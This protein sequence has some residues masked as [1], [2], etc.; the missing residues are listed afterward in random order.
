MQRFR[1][2]SLP[3]LLAALAAGCGDSA[4]GPVDGGGP[5]AAPSCTEDPTR[6]GCP[7]CAEDPSLAWCATCETD[8]SLHGCTL[9]EPVFP[10]LEGEVEILRDGTGIAH[11][12]AASDADAMY[13]SGYAQALDRL[14]QMDL[15]RRLALGRQA[16]V[17][18]EGRADRDETIRVMG[19]ADWA[20]ASAVRLRGEHAELY[21]LVTAWTAGVNA[22]IDEVLSGTAPLPYGFGADALDYEPEHWSVVDAMAVGRLLLFENANLI[23]YELLATIVR[24]YLPEIHDN[25]GLFEPLE[26]V[27]TL[28]PEDRPTALALD[29]RPPLPPRTA[30]HLPA[31]TDARMRAFAARLAPFRPS[32][33]NNWAIAGRHTENGRPLIASDPHQGLE[34]PS[35][36]WVHQVNSADAGGTINAVGFNFVGTPGIQLGHNARVAWTA[37][38]TYPDTMD[39]YEV[40]ATRTLV[41]VA[42]RGIPIDRHEEVIAVRDGAPRTILIDRVPGLGVLL[43]DDL[44]PLPVAGPGRRLLFRWTGFKP[45]NDFEVFWRFDTARDTDDFDAAAGEF[46]IG[47]FNWVAADAAGI[48]YRSGMLVPDRGDPAVHPPAF[49]VMDGD[50]PLAQWTGMFLPPEKLMR[51]RGGTRGWIATAN[52]DPFGFTSDGEVVGDPWYYGVFFDPG[53]RA[54]RLESEIT[55]LVARGAVTVDEMRALQT[56]THSVEAD[57]LIPLI[58]GAWSRVGTDPDLAPYQDRPELALLVE[59]LGAWDRR[60]VRDS[61]EAVVFDGLAYLAAAHTL[62]DDFDFIFDP[63]MDASGITMIKWALIALE[64]R[65]PRS[66]DLLQEG[67]DVILMAALSDTAAWLT[68]RFGGVDPDLF[69]YRWGDLHGTRFSSDCCALLDGGWVSTDGGDDTVNV[70]GARFFSAT[71][72]RDRLES[73]GGPIYR[74]IYSFDADGTPRAV[75]SF[76]RGVSGEPSSAWWDNTLDDWIEGRYRP[77]LF[78]RADVEAEE[79]E[80][81]VLTP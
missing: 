40:R 67:R 24:D 15:T 41:T 63:V 43:P 42:G 23:E 3:L 80:R 46:E 78:H 62:G 16:E 37:T 1:A 35:I 48:V 74:T 25:F 13:G 51:S 2:G 5:D 31:D 65:F 29:R 17:L 21:A 12:F 52:N 81:T 75:T 9:E 33:S 77:L 71:G 44:A 8:P 7:T 54:A 64:G 6:A 66:A 57:H 49:A 76:P 79:T 36:F 26:H 59:L 14:F 45:T 39:I 50:D 70:S 4:A 73:G 60:M 22:R 11:V 69:G 56:D 19:I 28:P 30:R 20:R 38:T 53:A 10:G 72:I 58:E 47:A 68:E 55:R 34:S 18:G 32:G 61:P 27:W